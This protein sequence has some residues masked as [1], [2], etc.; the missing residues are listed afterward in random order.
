MSFCNS[1]NIPRWFSKFIVSIKF[2]VVNHEYSVSISYGIS[3]VTYDKSS[4]QA[5]FHLESFVGMRVIPKGS[6]VRNFKSVFKSLTR[7]YWFL[8]GVCS[9]HGS[10]ETQS[11]PVN[12]GWFCKVV[13]N[14]DNKCV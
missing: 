11:M 7:Y 10:G 12:G 6:G 3:F 9:V 1:W 5:S 8:T 4:I 13:G 14:A 2:H